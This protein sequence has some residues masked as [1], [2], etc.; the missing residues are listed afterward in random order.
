M[1]NINVKVENDVIDDLNLIKNYY[2]DKLKVSFNQRETIARLINLTANELK[3][4]N[5]C[6]EQK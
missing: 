3:K 1:K 4:K 5:K 6:K 2:S